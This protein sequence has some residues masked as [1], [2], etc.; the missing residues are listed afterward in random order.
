[1]IH[2]RAESGD[3]KE[4]VFQARITPTGTYLEYLESIPEDNPLYCKVTIENNLE[5]VRGLN[6]RSIG[7]FLFGE[8]KDALIFQVKYIMEKPVFIL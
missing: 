5:K 2:F 4:Y 8:L 1:M 7:L 6:I 3:I